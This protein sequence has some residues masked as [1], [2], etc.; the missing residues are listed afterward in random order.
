MLNSPK[1]C[2]AHIQEISRKS[3]HSNTDSFRARE[4]GRNE[5]D[6]H[7]RAEKLELKIPVQTKIAMKLN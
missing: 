4:L 7:I 3:Y 1:T 2:I 5:K 6:L